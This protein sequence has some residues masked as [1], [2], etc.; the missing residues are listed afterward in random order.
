MDGY[1]DSFALEFDEDEQR[2]YLKAWGFEI[3]KRTV[4]KSRSAYH[5]DVEWYDTEEDQVF[6][7]KKRVFYDY[8]DAISKAFETELK[9]R[10]KKILL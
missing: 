7:N 2:A 3:R 4:S 1:S 6:K 8:D 5:N 9:K 10:L